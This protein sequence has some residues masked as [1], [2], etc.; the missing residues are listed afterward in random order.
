MSYFLNPPQPTPKI[1]DLRQALCKDSRFIK[2]M[3]LYYKQDGQ[4]K[5]WD[6]IHSHDSVSVMIYEQDLEAFVIVKQFRPAVFM[7]NNDGYIYE[8]C[9]GLVDKPKKTLEEIAAEEVFEECGY[10]ITPNRLQ[11]IT[12]FYT[13][14]GISG[15]RQTIFFVSVNKNDKHSLGGGI[16]DEKIEVLYLKKDKALEFINDETYHKTPALGF[17]INY[18]FYQSN[19]N[20]TNSTLTTAQKANK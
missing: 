2:P 5:N 14:V 9:A 6:I 19:Q 1:T 3:R 16:D 7:R 17:A 20:L 4:E 10:E 11:K 18:F 12:T 13:S 15:A 8:L